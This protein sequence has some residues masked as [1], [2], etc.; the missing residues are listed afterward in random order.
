M[1]LSEILVFHGGNKHSGE[2]RYPAFFAKNKQD[3]EWYALER[4]HT[5]PHLYSYELSP[6]KVLDLH[7]EEKKYLEIADEAGIEVERIN[8]LFYCQEIDDNGQGSGD[9]PNDLVYIKRFLK[10]LISHG[11]DTIYCSDVLEEDEIDVYIVLKPGHVRL[12]KAEKS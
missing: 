9:N 3:A 2:I 5:K 11:Y 10:K 6:G 4:N 1:R 12:I 8:G 7:K